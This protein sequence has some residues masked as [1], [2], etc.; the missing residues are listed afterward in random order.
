VA[1]PLSIA[2]VVPALEVV[3]V[4]Q[5]AADGVLLVGGVAELDAVLVQLPLPQLRYGQLQQQSSQW[6]VQ[7][8]QTREDP[9]VGQMLAAPFHALSAL[10]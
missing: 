4:V 8:C 6:G 7:W 5:G 9:L 10:G 2:A 1:A 3:G